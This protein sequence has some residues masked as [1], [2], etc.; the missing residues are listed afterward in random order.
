MNVLRYYFEYK[1]EC[2][3]DCNDV[4]KYYGYEMRNDDINK[5]CKYGN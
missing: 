4:K 2:F 1:N 5:K 3:K